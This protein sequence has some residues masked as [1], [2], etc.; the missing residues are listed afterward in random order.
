M[1]ASANQV[2][3]G[4]INYA[5]H[6]VIGHLPSTGKWI[7]GTAV[8]IASTKVNDM[9]LSLQNNAIAK[10]M[11]IID[12]EGMFDVDLI[13][14]NMRQSA[15][16]YGRMEIDIPIIGSMRF[17]ETDIDSLRGYIERG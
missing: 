3:N 8:G 17:T 10:S 4:I 9:V 5:D 11:G 6:E 12:E 2:V 16:K 15:M 1:K 13:V 7:L 14:D